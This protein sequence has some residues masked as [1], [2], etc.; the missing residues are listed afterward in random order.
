MYIYLGK[1]HKCLSEPVLILTNVFLLVMQ[2]LVFYA[3]DHFIFITLKRYFTS[4]SLAGNRKN[5]NT[6]KQFLVLK[7]QKQ[8][9]I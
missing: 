8:G 7:L 3:L 5:Q 2:H 6:A 9:E 1:Q 4:Q